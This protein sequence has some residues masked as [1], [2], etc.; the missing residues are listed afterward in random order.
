MNTVKWYYIV[1]T[2]LIISACM[3]VDTR[4]GEHQNTIT[5]D[6]TALSNSY[7]QLEQCIVHCISSY[8]A[9][10]VHTRLRTRDLKL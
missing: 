1:Q 5:S 6:V 4:R 7:V 10:V 9:G 2:V 3:S 8:V